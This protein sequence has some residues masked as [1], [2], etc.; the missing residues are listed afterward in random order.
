[1]EFDTVIH[2]GTLVTASETAR[3]DIGIRDGRIVGIISDSDYLEV[4]ITL[5]EQLEMGE[6]EEDY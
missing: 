3:G 6:P 1:M 2:G 4:A 5:M